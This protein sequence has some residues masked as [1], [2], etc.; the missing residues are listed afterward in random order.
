[1]RSLTLPE[2]DVAGQ[3]VEPR[4]WRDRLFGRAGEEHFQRRPSDWIR[5]GTG[6]LIL[7]VAANHAG[8]VTASER[9]LFDLVNTLPPQL[10]PVFTALY[11]LGALWAVGLVV[12][13]ALVGRR[14]RLARDLLVAG[15]LTWVAARVIGELVVAHES[16]GHGVRVATGFGGSPPFPA[17]R[18][19]VTVAIISAAGPYVTRATRVFGRVLVV[20]L[21]VA[22]LYLGRAFPND[23]FA[24]IV[25]GWTAA[26]AVHLLFGSPGG[27]PTVDQVRASLA[28]LGIAATNVRLADHQRAGSTMMLAEDAVGALRVKVIGRDEADARLFAKLWR[29]IFYRDSGPRLTLTRMQ[30]VEHEAYLM[31]VAREAGAR[32]PPVLSA[33][34]AGPG[35]ALLVQ[36]AV[37]A[38]RLAELDPGAVTD[39]LLREIWTNVAALHRA[40]ITHGLLDAEH[41]VVSPDGPWIVGFDDARATGDEERRSADVAELL[42]ATG[43]LVGEARA[44][45]AAVGVLGRPRLVAALP[46]LQA[47]ALTRTTRHLA[48]D[49]RGEVADLLRR[50]RETGAEAAGVEPPELIQLR[51]LNLTSLAMAIG[52]L[53][54]TAVL[55]DEVGDPGQVWTTVRGADWT[56]IALAFVFSFASNVGYA[57]GLMGTVPVRLPL[58][59]TTEVQLG[60]SFSNLAVPAIGGQGMQVRYLQKMGIDLS[61]AV[62]AGGVLSAVGNLVAALGLFVLAVVIAPAHADFSLLPTTGLLEVTVIVIVVVALASAVVLAVPTLRR[63][64]VPP[65]QRATS[66]MRAVLRSPYKLALLIGGN[67]VATLLSTACLFA[68]VAAFGGS[69]SFW[70]LLA[71]NIAVVTVA[72]IVPIPGGGTAVGTVGLSAV[73]VS[74]G[75]PDHIAVAASLTNQLIYYYLPAIPGW[76][77]TKHLFRH[78]YL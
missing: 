24:A 37:G 68:C 16:F 55:L 69:A 31:L 45:D 1:V 28:E 20:G 5:L 33:G 77:A 10:S 66:T 17:V 9:A 8:D 54:A 34:L 22:A 58:W 41:I 50:L 61:S 36:R 53:V 14:A 76:F 18:A 57:I 56:W 32:V 49:R 29:S 27:R 21:A 38:V 42:V 71:A 60:V 46:F 26:A 48:G 40:R 7:I 2:E 43:S 19:A 52:A 15:I 78:D 64:A 73:L 70:A 59:P 75:V 12:V 30:Q 63:I 39:D 4:R 51:R 62:A 65:V 72:S 11:R 6:I 35:A 13:A 25:L 23:L 44:V 47:G 74:F 67:V 3:P